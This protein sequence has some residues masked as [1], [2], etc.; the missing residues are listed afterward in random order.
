M[1]W[2]VACVCMRERVHTPKLSMILTQ[3]DAHVK[4]TPH[5]LLGVY[6]VPER[7]EQT[8]ASGTTS[9]MARKLAQRTGRPALLVVVRAPRARLTQANNTQLL[10]T[11]SA[12]SAALVSKGE[13]QSVPV[14]VPEYNGLVKRLQSDVRGGHWT[15]LVDFDDH[16]ENTK[17]DWLSCDI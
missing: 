12:L 9:A 7:L 13:P 8:D 17:L 1:L 4:T 16:L 6:E 15:A 2:Y 5:E 11:T 14:S 10:G 3:I